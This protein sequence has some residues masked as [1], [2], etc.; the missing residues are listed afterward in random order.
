MG[1]FDFVKGVGEK[2]GF[3]DNDDDAAK[4]EALKKE[5]D[6]HKLGT[7]GVQVEVKGDTDVL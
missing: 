6:S 2:L 5:L 3:G 1:I 7:D 4:A